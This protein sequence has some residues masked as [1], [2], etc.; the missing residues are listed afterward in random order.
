MIQY[1]YA[2]LYTSNLREYSKIIY[3]NMAETI[4]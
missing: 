4:G 2:K 3:V 1:I